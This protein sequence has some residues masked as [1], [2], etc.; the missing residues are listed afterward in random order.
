[1]HLSAAPAVVKALGLLWVYGSPVGLRATEEAI[2]LALGDAKAVREALSYLER[3]SIAVYRKFEEAYG[4]WEGS[5]V[6]LDAHYDEARQQI[7]RG[8]LARRLERAVELRPHVAR[9]HYVRTGTLRFFTIKAIDGSA[10]ALEDLFAHRE[11]PQWR[12]QPNLCA[13]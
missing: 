9:S 5:D 6:D 11:K 8:D 10:A 13:K 12:R 2:A 1:M 3:R 7:G 4:L